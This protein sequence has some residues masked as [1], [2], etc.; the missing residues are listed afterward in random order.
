MAISTFKGRA[1]GYCIH[2]KAPHK[3]IY[4]DFN[5]KCDKCSNC[6]HVF[7][8]NLLLRDTTVN[9]WIGKYTNTKTETIEKPKEKIDHDKI[10]DEIFKKGI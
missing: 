4:H 3:T 10:V 6:K 1:E 9:P 7:P 2:C 8:M 5:N